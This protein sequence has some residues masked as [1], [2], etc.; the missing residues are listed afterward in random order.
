VIP[1]ILSVAR[2]GLLL[3]DPEKAHELSLKALERG[4]Y[5][6]SQT[7]DDPR[8]AQTLWG[9]R[10]T[11]PLGMAAG[12]DKDARV[13][14]PLLRL[15]FGFTEVGTITPLPQQGNPR[16]RVFRLF[17][18]RAVINRMGFNNEGHDAA[19]ARLV[20]L[21]KT[22]PP[23][24][25]VGVNIGANKDSVDPV[26]DYVAGLCK[27]VDVADYFAVNISSP[28]TPGLRDLQGPE[29]LD[30][31]LERVIA[32][33]I[34]LV[35]AGKPWRPILVKLAPDIDDFDL[36]PIAETLL[37]RQVDGVILTNTT[38]ARDGLK[39]AANRGEKGGLSGQPLFTRSTRMLAK[40]YRLTQGRLPLIGVGGVDSGEAALTKILAGASL[41]ALYTG[42]IYQ[43][44]ALIGRIKG[45]LKD[46]VESEGLANISEAVGQEAG[47]WAKAEKR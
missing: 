6:K 26:A 28:N 10:F 9:L 33:R 39:S 2:A 34:Q 18:E 46:Y 14:T 17:R 19:L 21:G 11:N 12:F 41:V 5:A 36:S 20:R 24:G 1:Q 32:T 47:A 42:L 43:G 30:A 4:V 27:F 3:L 15:G 8:L 40:L 44:P 31:L 38:I 25:I 29:R 16:P 22:R 37:S 23:S 7:P 13:A 45:T 35:A